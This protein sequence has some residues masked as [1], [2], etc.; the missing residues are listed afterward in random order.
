MSALPDWR[1]V[2]NYW[3]EIILII[4]SVLSISG[5]YEF[6][7]TSWPSSYTSVDNEIDRQV[8]ANPFRSILLFRMGP[9][10]IVCFCSSV[11]ADRYAG[12][13]GLVVGLTVLFHLGLTNL[14]AMFI[15]LTGNR[16]GNWVLQIVYHL[17]ISASVVLAGLLSFWL[18]EPLK[19]IVPE[20][21]ALAVSFWAAVFTSIFWSSVAGL[22]RAKPKRIVDVLI[23]LID[24]TGVQNWRYIR[25]LTEHEED[26]RV[27]VMAT[28]LAE[29]QQR[30]KWFRN[31]E[32]A[33]VKLRS[34]GT[35]GV[36]QVRSST[37]VSDSESIEILVDSYRSQLV[38]IENDHSY[39]PEESYDSLRMGIFLRH[40]PDEEHARRILDFYYHL[41]YEFNELT[42][43]RR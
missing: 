2:Q 34:E 13:S 33:F 32:R 15:L 38:N 30:P 8:R 36:A 7:R 19:V 40:N 12:S 27:M 10:F 23:S 5:I 43:F 41:K 39:I 18:T 3:L 17:V 4:F 16:P 14:R 42:D 9:V 26:L 24:D 11:L 31:V 22:M 20:T 25:E 35:Y 21:D 28:I 29:V 1:K 6:I 37:P